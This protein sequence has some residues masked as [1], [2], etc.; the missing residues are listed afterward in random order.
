METNNAESRSENAATRGIKLFLHRVDFYTTLLMRF[1]EYI[2]QPLKKHFE[3][4]EKGNLELENIKQ[5][6]NRLKVRDL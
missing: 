6:M 3:T 5:K 4:S 1:E 2:L